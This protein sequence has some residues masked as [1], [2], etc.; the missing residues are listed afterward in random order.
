MQYIVI[1]HC[2]K[3]FEV[4]EMKILIH[5]E[6]PDAL[7]FL[8]ESISRFGFEVGVAK[9]SF[10]IINLLLDDQYN[11]VLTNGAYK[12]LNLDQHAKIQSLPV[13]VIGITDLQKRTREKDSTIQLYL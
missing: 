3:L 6:R 5:D 2:R 13:V 1:H 7:E 10:E 12:E 11:V 4:K 9:D 8:S